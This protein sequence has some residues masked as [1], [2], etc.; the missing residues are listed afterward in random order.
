M[1]ALLGGVV[2]AYGTFLL[3][4]AVAL[5]WQG[6]RPAPRPNRPVRPSARLAPVLADLGLAGHER[7]ATLAASAALGAAG[8]VL[9]SA[10]FGPGPAAAL[11]AAL[12]AAAPPLG[13]RA[14]RR[15]R[16]TTALDAWPGLIEELRVR[17]TASG[18]SVPQALFDVGARAPDELRPAF[19]EARREWLLSADLDRATAVLRRRLADATTDVVCETLLVAHHLGGADLDRRLVALGADRLA[20]RESRRDAEAKQAGA[21]F[22]R[23]FVLLV[24]AGMALAGLGIGNGRAAYETG[25]GQALATAAVAVIALCWVWAGRTM[26]LPADRRVFEP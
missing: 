22:A 23:R 9:A 24:P 20:D 2:A 3:F 13:A 8:G 11:A 21:R 18:R 1:S 6:L 15:R 25:Q 7:R 17:I 4:T 5:G 12:G 10:V 16:R 14:R 19:A 26:A